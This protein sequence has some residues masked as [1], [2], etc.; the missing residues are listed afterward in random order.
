MVK[1]IE[2]WSSKIKTNNLYSQFSTM[3]ITSD[4]TKTALVNCG[5]VKADYTGSKSSGSRA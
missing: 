2:C 3:V 1:Y 4:L 5:R